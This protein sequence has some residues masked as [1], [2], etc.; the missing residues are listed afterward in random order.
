MI[1]PTQHSAVRL[2]I[3]HWLEREH[4]QPHIVGEFEDSALLTTFG[5]AGMGVFPAP[6]S[7]DTEL[8]QMHSVKKIAPFAD[9]QEQFHLIYTTRKILH[10]LLNRLLESSV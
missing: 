6:D 8:Q 2:R 9:V 5:A 10:P 3:D 4:I 7:L 1:L